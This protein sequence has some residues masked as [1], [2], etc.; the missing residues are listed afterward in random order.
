MHRLFTVFALAALLAVP[1]TRVSA[2]EPNPS[3]E[4]LTMS[5]FLEQAGFSLSPAE[6]NFLDTDQ[7]VQLQWVTPL[8]DMIGLAGPDAGLPDTDTQAKIVADLQQVLALDPNAAPQAPSSLQRLRELAVEQRQALQR[9]ANA[10]LSALQAG[11]AEWRTRGGDDFAA[12]QQSLAAWN[13]EMFTRY[14]P[15]EQPPS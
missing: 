12:A 13:Q 6:V 1:A 7:Q 2:Q 9:A 15:P 10:W 3:Q 8:L 11:D 5:Q 4:P 14:P